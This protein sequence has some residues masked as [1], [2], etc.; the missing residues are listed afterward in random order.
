MSDTCSIRQFRD[1]ELD[2]QI[3]IAEAEVLRLE[4]QKKKITNLHVKR[5]KLQKLLAKI[6]NLKRFLHESSIGKTESSLF[7]TTALPCKMFTFTWRF[8]Y[9]KYAIQHAISAI[10]TDVNAARII[11]EREICANYSGKGDKNGIILATNG[12]QYSG[13]HDFIKNHIPEVRAD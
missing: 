6:E 2:A 11:A 9:Q 4:D 8:K 7:V 1:D 3:L 5:T 12:I 13:L 10:T